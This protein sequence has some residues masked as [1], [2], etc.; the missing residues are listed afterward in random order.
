MPRLAVPVSMR[1]TA[2][3]ST[4]SE[5]V[6]WAMSCG[7]AVASDGQTAHWLAVVR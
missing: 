3:T 7:Y 4:P 2:G 6:V 1:T 5:V